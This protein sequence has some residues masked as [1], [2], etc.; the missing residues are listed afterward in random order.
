MSVAGA[1][2]P[3]RAC[4]APLREMLYA[5]KV[6]AP[7]PP[8]PHLS[9]APHHRYGS[10]PVITGP[11]VTPSPRPI[12]MSIFTPPNAAAARALSVKCITC[13]APEDRYGCARFFSPVPLR[14]IQHKQNMYGRAPTNIL[15]HWY[16]EK[17]NIAKYKIIKLPLIILVL[18]A[19]K[20]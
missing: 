5:C 16:W 19:S 15:L 7:P 18:S 20:L 12:V 14:A 3:P 4:G 2:A 1:R 9:G 6:N 10:R 8:P 17:L 11:R 13:D